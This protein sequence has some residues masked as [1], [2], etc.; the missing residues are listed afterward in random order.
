[1]K[2]NASGPLVPK[3]PGRGSLLMAET[4]TVGETVT[5][6]PVTG[7]IYHNEQEKPTMR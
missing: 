1:M 4:D 7:A 5:I 6:V 3:S 2:I